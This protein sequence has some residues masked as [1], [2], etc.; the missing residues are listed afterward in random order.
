MIAAFI[1]SAIALGFLGSFHCVG[2]CGPI[3]LSLPVQHLKGLNKLWHSALYSGRIAT[4]NSH[5]S[6]PSG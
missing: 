5:C 1:I 4:R 3:A 2:M 6:V